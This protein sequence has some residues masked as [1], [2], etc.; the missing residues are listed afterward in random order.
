MTSELLIQCIDKIHA[1]GEWLEVD[2]AGRTREKILARNRVAPHY[3]KL[4]ILRDQSSQAGGLSN[5]LIAG[6]L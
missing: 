2:S 6:K 5:K 4:D 3:P 1:G